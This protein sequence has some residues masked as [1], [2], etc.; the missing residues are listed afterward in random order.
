MAIIHESTFLLLFCTATT[1]IVWGPFWKSQNPV[2]FWW[3]NQFRDLICLSE[4]LKE[5][6]VKVTQLMKI[7]TWSPTKQADKILIITRLNSVLYRQRLNISFDIS[8]IS[9][10]H[11]PPRFDSFPEWFDLLCSLS[12]WPSDISDILCQFRTLKRHAFLKTCWCSIQQFRCNL[13][14]DSKI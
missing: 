1:V 4:E 3:L 13:V 14:S 8:F 2:L 5:N 6:W 9:E 7:S 11:S 12:Q 10:F